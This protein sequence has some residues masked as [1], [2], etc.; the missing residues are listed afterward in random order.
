MDQPFPP[1]PPSSSSSKSVSQP[2]ESN[3]RPPS[4]DKEP[5]PSSSR[6]LANPE[7]DAAAK[8]GHNVLVR[9]LWTFIMIGGF[10]GQSDK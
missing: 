8:K 1:V 5:A 2:F 7:A 10:M 6:P 3:S 9:T 4:T